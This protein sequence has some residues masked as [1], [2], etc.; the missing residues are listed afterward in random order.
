MLMRIVTITLAVFLISPTT[1]AGEWIDLLPEGDLTKH[2]TTE[3]N[4]KVTDGVVELTPRPGEKGWSRWSSYLWLKGD[5]IQDFE[6]EFEYMVQNRGNSG[7]YF[8]VGDKNSPVKNGIEVQIYDSAG[9]KKLSDHDSGGIIPGIAPTKDAAKPAGEWNKFHITA[10]GNDLTVK[11][12]GEV[13][14]EVKLDQGRVK[15]RPKTGYIGFQ[16]HALP[17]KLRNMRMKK[18]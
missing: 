1:K 7:F 13:V 9:K 6:F 2:W 18:L 5:P 10:K 14:N 11:L 17:L 8:H 15:D 3:G 12:N 4:W 16:D